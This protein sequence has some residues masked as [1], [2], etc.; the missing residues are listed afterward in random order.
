MIGK[1]Y[2]GRIA[3][4]MEYGCFVTLEGVRGGRVDGL[5]HRSQL[6]TRTGEALR[7]ETREAFRRG[8]AVYVKVQSV[9]GSKISL[10]MKDIDQSTG[11]DRA[12]AQALTGANMVPMGDMDRSTSSVDDGFDAPRSR[13]GMLGGAGAG[14]GRRSFLSELASGVSATTYTDADEVRSKLNSKRLSS[15]E[16][17]ELKQLAAAGVL[18]KSDYPDFDEDLGG[19]AAHES[20]GEDMDIERVEDEPPFLRGQTHLALDMSPVKIIKNPDGSMQRAAQTQS[21]LAR[22][23]REIRQAHRE[24]EQGALPADLNVGR[25]P[26]ICRSHG[27]FVE[28]A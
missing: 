3:N 19:L 7:A 20:D 26:C 1:V 2:H 9:T 8:D 5:A 23:R 6:V 28:R 13:L 21:S 12:A 17:F 16:R 11:K 27:R 4:I 14:G 10:T 15:P 25:R 22:E 24:A 18:K